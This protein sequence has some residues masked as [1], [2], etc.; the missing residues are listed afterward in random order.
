MNRPVILCL[1]CAAGAWANT[2]PTGKLRW[3][4][5][6][7][8]LTT[9]AA[10][11][12]VWV[13]TR[14]AL[15]HV[16]AD[17]DVLR[18]VELKDRFLALSSDGRTA[19]VQRAGTRV[20]HVNVDAELVAVELASGKDLWKVEQ[21]E[22]LESRVSDDGQLLA[23]VEKE[24]LARRDDIARSTL[25]R[26]TVVETATGKVRLRASLGQSVTALQF[27]PDNSRV[28][29]RQAGYSDTL[30]LADIATGLVR[31]IKLPEPGVWASAFARDGKTLWVACEKVYRVA[32]DS[33]AATAVNIERVVQLAA[34]RDGMVAGTSDGR[35]LWLGNAGK[36][37]REVNL[38]GGIGV[39]DIHAA[40]VPLR[41][42]KLVDSP[43]LRPNEFPST[44]QFLFEYPR[45]WTDP[46]QIR[47][48]GIC[49]PV[50]AVRAPVAGKY[51]FT[52]PLLNEK[53]ED[54]K[55]GVFRLV[56]DDGATAK[57]E[58][59]NGDKWQQSAVLELKPGVWTIRIMADNWKAPPLLREMKI[60]N[61]D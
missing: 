47:G 29:V 10:D 28:L 27:A 14:T 32:T 2:D 48:D 53:S 30:Y 35:V 40:L 42:A 56:S 44:V 17:G 52:I 59:L 26:L 39:Q 31:Q 12:S 20:G 36:V 57:T 11:G 46:L 21:C 33:L 7:E 22:A 38:A 9:P 41:D 3:K 16:S 8:P 60:E 58:S 4:M 6:G 5:V 55:I 23:C 37:Q 34:V 43:G 24:N 15:K 18:S 19:F 51:R 1:L 54:D 13:K 49:P 50:V 45:P 61:A 25:A